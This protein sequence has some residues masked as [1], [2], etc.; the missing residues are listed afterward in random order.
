M[1]DVAKVLGG[2]GAV[3]ENCRLP[4][5]DEAVAAYYVL[6]SAEASSELGRYDGVRFGHRAQNCADGEELFVRSRTEGFGWEVKRRIL[7]G[8]YALSAGHYE[9]VYQKALRVRAKV[10]AQFDELF[11]RYDLLL[12]PVYCGTAPKLGEERSSL[13]VWQGDRYTIPASLAGLPA[14][15]IPCGFD[16]Q[17]MPIGAQLIGPAF[18][19]QTVLNA[20][21]AFQRATDWH[22]RTPGG[23]AGA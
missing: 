16:R 15:S 1:L 17:G 6:S 4:V 22:R 3:Y 2:Q 9:D 13:A 21:H 5:M 18:G 14:I 10:K 8:T 12:A 19:D 23:G 11:R 20:A 7:L